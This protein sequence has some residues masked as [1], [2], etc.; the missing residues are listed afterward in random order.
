MVNQ[1]KKSNQNNN[2]EL[3]KTDEYC[4]FVRGTS[5]TETKRYYSHSSDEVIVWDI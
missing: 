4:K 3:V 5:Q 2:I 1:L